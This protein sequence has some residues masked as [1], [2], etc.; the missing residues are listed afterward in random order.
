MLMSIQRDFS[1]HGIF[2]FTGFFHSRDFFNPHLKPCFMKECHSSLQTEG[3]MTHLFPRGIFHI[4]VGRFSKKIF[5]GGPCPQIFLKDVRRFSTKQ[6][7]CWYLHKIN[8]ISCARINGYFYIEN[9]LL[10]EWHFHKLLC[11]EIIFPLPH[12]TLSKRFL[13]FLKLIFHHTVRNKAFLNS[14]IKLRFRFW[15]L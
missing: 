9:P 14:F 4:F 11:K 2:P 7:K 5:Y 12:L 13:E 15:S 10:W 8:E 1:I 6:I 3:G